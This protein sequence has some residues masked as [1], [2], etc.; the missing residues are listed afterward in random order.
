MIAYALIAILLGPCPG[1]SVE[2]EGQCYRP[3]AVIMGDWACPKGQVVDLTGKGPRCLVIPK[4]Q[5]YSPHKPHGACKGLFME[6]G[7]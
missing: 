1:G 4:G 3:G 2:F 5:V 6:E 7:S